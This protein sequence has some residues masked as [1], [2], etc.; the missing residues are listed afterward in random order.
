MLRTLG[1]SK[2]IFLS[3]HNFAVQNYN[4]FVIYARVSD[5]FSRTCARSL[6]YKIY[7]Y[8]DKRIFMF[9]NINSQYCP[10]TPQNPIFYKMRIFSTL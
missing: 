6:I 8:E 7:T 9:Y 5:I 2:F 3:F 4:F 10:K 1:K